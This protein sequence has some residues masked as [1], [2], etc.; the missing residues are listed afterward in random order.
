[1]NW[2]YIAGYFDGE[3]TVNHYQSTQGHWTRGLHWY[4][5]HVESLNLMQMFMGVGRVSTRPRGFNSL[6]KET[7]YALAVTDKLGMVHVLDHILPHLIIKRERAQALRDHLDAVRA[8]PQFGVVERLPEGE[9]ERL[10]VTE[11]LSVGSIAKQLGVT[12]SAVSAALARRGIEKRS[13]ASRAGVPKSE[14]TKARM[15]V[16][17]AKRWARPEYAEI[18][19]ANLAVGRGRRG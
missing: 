10:Y 4:N 12:Y 3:G 11:R 6:G 8:T 14:E 18:A 17:A 15:R 7:Q 5:N 13:R 16:A 1:M 9:L 2:A 19:Q